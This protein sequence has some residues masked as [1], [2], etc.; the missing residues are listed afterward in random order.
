M[1]VR[2]NKVKINRWNVLDKI[3]LGEILQN[4]ERIREEAKRYSSRA[5]LVYYAN[6]DKLNDLQLKYIHKYWNMFEVKN[7]IE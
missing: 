2:E 3:Y 4:E 7:N 6:F 5:D 1:F